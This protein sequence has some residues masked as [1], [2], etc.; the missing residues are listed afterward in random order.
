MWVL[1]FVFALLFS[2]LCPSSFAINLM[3]KIELGQCFV[4][5]PHGAVGWYAVCDCGIS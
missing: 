1:C 5:R 2:T 3:G 4:A